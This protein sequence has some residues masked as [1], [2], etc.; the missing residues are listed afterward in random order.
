MKRRYSRGSKAT[1]FATAP[2]LNVTV[3]VPI[4]VPPD[5]S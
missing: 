4:H 2:R 1:S 3:F 5:F